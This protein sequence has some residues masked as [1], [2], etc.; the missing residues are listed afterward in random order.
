MATW[1]SEIKA[2]IKTESWPGHHARRHWS[3]PRLTGG[4]WRNSLRVGRRSREGY[5][6]SARELI[7]N[8]SAPH[9]WCDSEFKVTTRRRSILALLHLE[10]SCEVGTV[11]AKLWHFDQVRGIVLNMNRRIYHGEICE[12]NKYI[13]GSRTSFT[14]LRNRLEEKKYRSN[15]RA[16]R[17]RVSFFFGLVIEQS[18]IIRN[19]STNDETSR[20]RKFW[21]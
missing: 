11:S 15:A 10:E 9:A 12:I 2:W 7:L 17:N 21:F 16:C 19:V 6:G 3:R 13:E 4:E 5:K 14:A 20:T 8:A 1:I 18:R